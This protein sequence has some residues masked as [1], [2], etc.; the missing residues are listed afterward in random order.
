MCGV[1]LPQQLTLSINIL[2]PQW[3]VTWCGTVGGCCSSAKYSGEILG[4]GS[5]SVCSVNGGGVHH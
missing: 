1:F 4:L 5:S 2:D 3:G